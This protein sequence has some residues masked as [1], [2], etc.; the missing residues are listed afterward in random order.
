MAE[1]STK[2]VKEYLKRIQGRVTT[3]KDLRTEF[4]I[5]RGDKSFDAIRNIVWQLSEQGIVRPTGKNDGSYKV[6]TEVVPVQVFGI[7]R[8]KIPRFQLIFPREYNTMR[9]M[10]FAEYIVIREG[11]LV[12]VTGVSNYGKGHPDGT[13][14][15]APTGWVNVE[16]VKVGDAIFGQDGNPHNVI[17]VYPRGVQSC[18]R[19]VFDDKSYV[20]TDSDHLWTIRKTWGVGKFNWLTKSVKQIISTYGDF[21]KNAKNR[22]EIPMCEPIQFPR[23][24]IPLS[25][26]LLGLLLGDGTLSDTTPRFSTADTELL[27]AF[28]SSGFNIG[29]HPN[30]YDYSIIGMS[31]IIGELNIRAKSSDK[32]IPDKYLYNSP[33]V[34]LSLLRGLMD[35]DGSINKRGYCEFTST[36]PALVDGVR[37]LISSMGGRVTP[38]T[39]SINHYKYRGEIRNGQV[40]YRLSF[41]ANF[42][43]FSLKRKASL[44]KPPSKSRNRRIK[45]IEYIGEMR[46][47]C[48]RVD[49]NDGLYITKDCIV[50][51]NTT[52][53]LNICGENIDK[54]PVLMGN[55]YTVKLVDKDKK[56]YYDPAP[57]FLNRIEAM[58]TRNG[59]WINWVDENGKDKFL[60]LPVRDDY[61]EHIVK[62]RINIIDWINIDTGEL[63]TI[64][65]VLESIKK[66]LGRGV[67][68]VALQKK[69]GADAGR[70]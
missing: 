44:W 4:G 22:I 55:E 52:I 3:L 34:R 17:G 9:E 29:Q 1:I 32:H 60:L 59:G 67:A 54:R 50:T 37:F 63:Y 35:T 31:D 39:K 20:D 24:S 68:V 7:T 16:N 53:C 25:P 48:L 21:S 58:D 45:H 38:Y 14:I 62:D 51:H 61:A 28:T 41:A 42:N 13:P 33:D 11:D 57:R 12:L 5:Q 23:Q 18:Y 69:E 43:P 26:Y 8:E 2:E 10:D 6:I 15:L 30:K 49:T 56:E 47:T 64:G 66:Q 19:F 36:S 27:Q 65:N 46:T 40:S 70:G